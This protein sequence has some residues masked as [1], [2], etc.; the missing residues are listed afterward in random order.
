MLLAVILR[1]HLEHVMQRDTRVFVIVSP[2]FP[3]SGR[4][5]V[6]RRVRL[7]ARLSHVVEITR[8]IGG[9]HDWRAASIGRLR[10]ARYGGRRGYCG[11]C[12][13]WNGRLRRRRRLRR[14]QQIGQGAQHPRL[15]VQIAAC[16]RQRR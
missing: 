1:V 5:P 15:G 7:R 6:A 10:A 16:P 11:R 9:R 2:E 12:R 13:V 8:G 4:L 14:R 3:H